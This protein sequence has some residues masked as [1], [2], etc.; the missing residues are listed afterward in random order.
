MQ[1]QSNL[2]FFFFYFEKELERLFHFF[3]NKDLYRAVLKA[4]NY[5][6]NTPFL[7]LYSKLR[8]LICWVEGISFEIVNFNWHFQQ[9]YKMTAVS[10]WQVCRI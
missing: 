7:C 10:S 1:K 4:V 8:I 6:L 3:N 2:S 9:M 5:Y